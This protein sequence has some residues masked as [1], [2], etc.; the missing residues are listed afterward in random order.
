MV[1]YLTITANQTQVF[2]LES[3]ELLIVATANDVIL[4]FRVA[5]AKDPQLSFMASGGTVVPPHDCVC[6]MVNVP[7]PS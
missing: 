5:K 7:G 3:R 4:T 6:W 1:L 2:F